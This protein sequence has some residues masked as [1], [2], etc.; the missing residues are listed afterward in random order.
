MLYIVKFRP[1]ESV[2][3]QDTATINK[4]IDTKLIPATEAVEGVRSAR[5]YQSFAGEL[6][7]I[8]DIEN[9]AAVDNILAD[10]G[11]RAVFSEFYALTVRAGGDVLYD[12]PSFQKLWAGND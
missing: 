6:V 12:R 9:L 4:L 11:C 5:M 2:T 3:P 7:T 8:V 10:P 1:K